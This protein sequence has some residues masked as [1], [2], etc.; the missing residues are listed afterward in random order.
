MRD[1]ASD[2]TILGSEGWAIFALDS[3][4]FGKL[5]PRA[6]SFAI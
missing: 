1:L 5:M 2:F 6:A 3:F 4:E